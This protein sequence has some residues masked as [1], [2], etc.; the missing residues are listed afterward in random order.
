MKKIF[1]FFALLICGLGFSQ[2][3]IHMID[4][5]NHFNILT[6]DTVMPRN[7]GVGATRTE[8]V[9]IKN[10]SAVTHTYSVIKREIKLN[11]ALTTN[12]ATA[13]FC[14]GST[15]YGAG[16]FTAGSTVVL[17]PGQK[18][19]DLA[20]TYPLSVDF[21][22]SPTTQGYSYIKYVIY[23][24]NNYSDSAGVAWKYNQ[25]LGVKNV[26]DVLESVSNVY[27]N[28]SHENASVAITLKSDA[29][30]KVQ[31]YNS[32]GALVYN[33]ANQKFTP[34]KH[35]IAI[36]CSDLNSGLYFVS[37]LAGENKITKRLIVNK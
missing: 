23:D 9:D 22:E 25:A 6:N 35:N 31:V 24:I 34:G 1:T 3:S 11:L 36:N 19:S 2:T 14:F 7:V 17:T 30:V 37:V 5:T 4:T 15:C 29:D 32:L 27:P 13:Y 18:I 33:G 10:I 8:V 16:T 26:A 21:D 28:P 12:S 20:G